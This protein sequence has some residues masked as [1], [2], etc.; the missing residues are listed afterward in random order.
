MEHTSGSNDCK[1]L[2]KGNR[3]RTLSAVSNG[4][5]QECYSLFL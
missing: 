2:P 4:L 5:I 1:N 3:F